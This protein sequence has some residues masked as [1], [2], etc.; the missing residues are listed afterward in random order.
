M[1]G[2]PLP[3][4]WAPAARTWRLS[5]PPGLVRGRVP[6]A[7]GLGARRQDVAAQLRALPG[8]R[9]GEDLEG[10]AARA[11]A[12]AALAGADDRDHALLVEAQQLAQAQLEPGGDP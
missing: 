11:A 9:R 12:A 8:Q 3:P 6:L 4:V 7:A 10:V 1:G 5:G 2:S